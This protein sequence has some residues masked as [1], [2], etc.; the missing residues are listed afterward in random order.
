M[1]RLILLIIAYAKIGFFIYISPRLTEIISIK[2][3]FFTLCAQKN[4]GQLSPTSIYLLLRSSLWHKQIA[5]E[6]PNR[7]EEVL[8]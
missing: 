8:H 1:N 7:K 2:P 3:V 6:L 5:T 4:A